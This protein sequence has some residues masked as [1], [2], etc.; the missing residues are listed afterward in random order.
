MSFLTVDT[1]NLHTQ[2]VWQD[3]VERDAHESG[4]SQS[5]EMD[6]ADAHI[7][8]GSVFHTDVAITSIR[9]ATKTLRE[10]LKSTLSSTRFRTP[11]AEI[12]P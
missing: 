7:V 11:T 10:E 9:A 3:G 1:L 4:E 2:F 6:G 8:V 12:M 5:G